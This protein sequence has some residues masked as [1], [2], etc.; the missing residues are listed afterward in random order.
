MNGA[1]DDEMSVIVAGLCNT[2]SDY[3]TTPE[4]Y[5]VNCLS[6]L[7]NIRIHSGNRDHRFQD[8]HVKR[9]GLVAAIHNIV[10]AANK[11]ILTLR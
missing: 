8:S 11:I 7:P 6:L 2:Y 1:S 10:N 9:I 3:V 4:E 5:Q